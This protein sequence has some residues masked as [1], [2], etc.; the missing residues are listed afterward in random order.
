MSLSQPCALSSTLIS[1]LPGVALLLLT[2]VE[3]V[4][5]QGLCSHFCG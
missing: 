1:S 4:R 3:P 2:L 5:G